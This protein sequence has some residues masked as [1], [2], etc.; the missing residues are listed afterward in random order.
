MAAEGIAARAGAAVGGDP[1]AELRLPA[2]ETAAGRERVVSAIDPFAFDQKSHRLYLLPLPRG[3]V[4]GTT[5]ISAGAAGLPAPPGLTQG[6]P[7]PNDRSER[8]WLS[9]LRLGRKPRLSGG[10]SR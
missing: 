9:P 5:G 4:A 10:G 8:G 1:V 3:A 2:Q 6:C 7:H